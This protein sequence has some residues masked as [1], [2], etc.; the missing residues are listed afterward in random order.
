MANTR[1]QDNSSGY[2][3]GSY[4]RAADLE[5]EYRADHTRM[6]SAFFDQETAQPLFTDEYE[7]AVAHANQGC[8][9]C[10]AFVTGARRDAAAGRELRRQAA[11]RNNNNSNGSLRGTSDYQALQGR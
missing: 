7:R 3:P 9:I 10:C 4:T 6:V 1:A 5:Q 8:P 2:Q 11:A